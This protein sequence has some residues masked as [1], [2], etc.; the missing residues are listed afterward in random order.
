LVLQGLLAQQV[1]LDQL[2]QQV[3]RDQRALEL[4]V[5]V[6]LDHKARLE[7]LELLG[8]PMFNPFQ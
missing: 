7:R 2:A 3:Q 5:L 6:L 4:E 8:H 1:R